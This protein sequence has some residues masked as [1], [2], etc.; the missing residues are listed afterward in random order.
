MAGQGQLGLSPRYFSACPCANYD[1][2]RETF[3]KPKLVYFQMS[4]PHS[5]SDLSKH[6]HPKALPKCQGT[7]KD[8]TCVWP[9]FWFFPP[10]HF[11]AIIYSTNIYHAPTLRQAPFWKLDLQRNEATSLPTYSLVGKMGKPQTRMLGGGC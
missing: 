9:H 8:W 2:V 6:T 5:A 1:S 11:H 3:L 7:E 4:G 10:K